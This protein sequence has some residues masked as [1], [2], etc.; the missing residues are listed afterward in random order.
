MAENNEN[1][2]KELPRPGYIPVQEYPP[3]Y[4]HNRRMGVVKEQSTPVDDTGPTVIVDG[5]E[6][7]AGVLRCLEN[8]PVLPPSPAAQGIIDAT[9]RRRAE[10][11]AKDTGR[12]R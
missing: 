3:Q 1:K 10:A 4:W 8:A 11:T 5:N 9:E 6:S 2:K 12:K 7:Q